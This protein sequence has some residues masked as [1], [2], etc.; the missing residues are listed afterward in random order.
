MFSEEFSA[1][2]EVN[3]MLDEW[4][5]DEADGINEE[6]PASRFQG[7]HFCLAKRF[8]LFIAVGGG[9]GGWI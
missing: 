4:F 5:A 2:D 8:I 7:T 3:D 6:E 9:V 1:L